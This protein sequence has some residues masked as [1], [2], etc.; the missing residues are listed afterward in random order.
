M[1]GT[2]PAEASGSGVPAPLGAAPATFTSAWGNAVT[3]AIN[4]TQQQNSRIET[5]VTTMASTQS[6]EAA[7]NSAFRKS[8]DDFLALIQATANSV[9]VEGINEKINSLSDRITAAHAV[10]A[11][12]TKAA[13]QT[14]L[15]T[16]ES[17]AQA[18]K[19]FGPD[20]LM[21]VQHFWPASATSNLE[22][23][24][25]LAAHLQAMQQ[26]PGMPDIPDLHSQQVP[27][28]ALSGDALRAGAASGSLPPASP[29]APASS[30]VVSLPF[31]AAMAGKRFK[32]ELPKPKFFS[33]ISVDFDIHRWLVRMQ[34]FLTLAGYDVSTW[35]VIASQYFDKVPLQLWEA[36][37]ARLVAE[38]STEVYAWDSFAQWCLTSFNVQNQERH[39]LTELMSLRQNGSVAEYKAAH[40]VLAAQSD[41]PEMQRLIYWEAGLK[42]EIAALCK[43]DPATHTG[44]TDIAKAQ[45]AAIA[46]DLHLAAAAASFS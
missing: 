38:R 24:T 19:S 41:L 45:S 11:P 40:D 5:I 21:S 8:S 22:V 20:W 25:I 31:A 37:K 46:T 34:E 3:S 16:D 35:A 23:V 39:T 12:T 30:H 28:P 32:A 18:I 14:A 7:A 15:A 26:D 17:C 42:P 43:F 4:E 13:V 9:D 36:R 44:Y 10:A 2:G 33:K 1:S 29:A 27:A 6:A